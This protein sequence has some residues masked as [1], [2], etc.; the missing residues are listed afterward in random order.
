MSNNLELLKSCGSKLFTWFIRP[1]NIIFTTGRLFLVTGFGGGILFSSFSIK[2]STA[3]GDNTEL[4]F[5]SDQIPD[6]IQ[7]GLWLLG[8]LGGVILV[9]EVIYIA[10]DRSKKSVI[11][12]EHIGLKKR[13][14]TPLSASLGK[15]EIIPI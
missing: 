6:F 4:N 12:I 2:H 11:G 3:N 1:K 14:A 15:A 9:C 7:N 8:F 10:C 5:T 13:I